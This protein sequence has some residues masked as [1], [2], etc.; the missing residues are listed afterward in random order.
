MLKRKLMI[1][2]TLVV[3]AASTTFAGWK[4]DKV[5][6]SLSVGQGGAVYFS[7]E[8]E[9]AYFNG[10]WQD[11]LFIIKKGDRDDINYQL[12]YEQLRTAIANN[13]TITIHSS[14]SVKDYW[15]NPSYSVYTV[16]VN[17]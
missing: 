9:R 2:A 11:K 3:A 16:G 14:D 15:G 13:K 12:Q 10:K 4:G 1:A 17:K 6:T 7:L 5:I 8:G